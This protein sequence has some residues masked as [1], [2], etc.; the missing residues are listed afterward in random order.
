MEAE[1]AAA[2]AAPKAKAAPRRTGM[3][4]L[5]ELQKSADGPMGMGE[6]MPKIPKL[7]PL[8]SYDTPENKAFLDQLKGGGVPKELQRRDEAGKPISVSIGVQDLRPKTYKELAAMISHF[9]KMATKAGGGGDS[10][11]AA[12]S[13]APKLFAGSGHTLSASSSAAQGSTAASAPGAKTGAGADP[14]LLALLGAAPAPVADESKPTTTLQLRLASGAR[15]RVKLNFDHTVADL[16]RLVAE[17]MGKD[18]FA[19][20][21]DHELSAGFPPK[22]LKDPGAT[23]AAADLANASITTVASDPRSVVL[24]LGGSGANRAAPGP[25]NPMAKFADFRTVRAESGSRRMPSAQPSGRS[26]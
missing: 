26:S 20:A 11:P 9:E 18:A 16:W 6:K 4:T 21:S 3:M 2:A 22:S 10:A 1:E 13:S 8:R 7:P 12:A 17:Q 25:P 5:D 23:L 24:A 14:A 19:A 15:S